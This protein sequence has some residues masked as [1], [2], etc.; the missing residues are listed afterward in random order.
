M[1][2]L[3]EK[4]HEQMIQ[5]VQNAVTD[6]KI[7]IA[8]SGGV[9][10]SLLAK[11]C[12]DL[13]YDI[14]LLTVGFAGS[15]DVEFSKEIAKMFGYKH[16]I[17]KIT[18]KMF[19]Q[20]AKK[21]NESI[22]TDNLSWNENC[23][24]FYYLSK[25]AK[26]HDIKKILTANGI[27]ELFCGYNGYREAIKDGED[28]VIK[29]MES[30]LENEINMIQAINNVISEFGVQIVQPFLAKDFISFVK[31]VPIKEKIH[32]PDDLIRKHI[33]RELAFQIGVPRDSSFKRKK[34]LQYGTLIHKTLMKLK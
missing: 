8:F 12:T 11:I 31:K 20:I 5:S 33:I 13:G 23:I 34:A 18:S 27:D 24:A 28:A 14:T 26:R 21:I 32:S 6:K 19:P 3:K 2:N 15:H 7:G 30:K 25:L 29:L 10:S 1:V 9:D 4:L 17:E 22:K 16:K